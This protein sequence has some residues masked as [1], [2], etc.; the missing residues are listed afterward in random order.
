MWGALVGK[1]G[2]KTFPR[3]YLFGIILIFRSMLMLY[4]LK[5]KLNQGWG[6]PL[7]FECKQ[8]QMDHVHF[9]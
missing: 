9:I 7:K 5:K 6:K 1:G 2:A 4:I 8:R 3:G